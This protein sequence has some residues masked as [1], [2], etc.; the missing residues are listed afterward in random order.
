MEVVEFAEGEAEGGDEG[1][2][3]VGGFGV[4]DLEGE[5]G[6]VERVREREGEAFVPD[7]FSGSGIVGFG[8]ESAIRVDPEDDVRLEGTVFPVNVLEVLGGDDG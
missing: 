7:G 6:V 2:G 1:F 4:E 3:G 5:E 8:G